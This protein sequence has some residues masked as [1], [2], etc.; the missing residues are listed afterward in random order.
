[1]GSAS[2]E[3]NENGQVISYEEYHPFGTSAYR[4]ARSGTDLSLKRYRFTNKERDDETGLYYFGVRYYA[5]WLGRWTSSDP[6]DFVDGLNMYVYAQ[7]NPV[8]LVDEEGYNAVEP[9]NRD[10]KKKEEGGTKEGYFYSTDGRLLGK[11]GD[12]DNVFVL[13]TNAKNLD[14]YIANNET[15]KLSLDA[16]QIMNADGKFMTHIQFFKRLNYNIGESKS[17]SEYYAYIINEYAKEDGEDDFYSESAEYKIKNGKKL[18]SRG[19]TTVSGYV[20]A[21]K[22][23]EAGF[24]F[25]KEHSKTFKDAFQRVTANNIK[26]L[27]GQLED[28]TGGEI[29]NGNID[30]W[31]GQSKSIDYARRV[32]ALDKK[33]VFVVVTPRKDGGVSS[34]SIFHDI[35]RENEK[36]NALTGATIVFNNVEGKERYREHIPAGQSYKVWQKEREERLE[37]AQKMFD[38]MKENVTKFFNNA[39]KQFDY[40]LKTK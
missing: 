30:H 26:A 31:V 25:T 9:E 18:P 22:Y 23:K 32:H 36:V 20:K 3:T 39:K 15:G 28:P 21:T 13:E 37:N 24:K 11:R 8:K 12:S 38:D 7:N 2:L 27:R 6:G 29:A 4:T 19:G 40:F 10:D 34:Y 5:A 16:V 35:T 17:A 33:N 1:L 14:A